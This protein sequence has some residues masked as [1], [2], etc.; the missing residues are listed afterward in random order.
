MTAAAPPRWTAYEPLRDV[1]PAVRNPKGHDVDRIAAS[2]ARFGFVDGAV[3]DGRTGRFIAGHGRLEAL[4]AME[5]RGDEPP[6]GV[7][8]GDRGWEMPVQM[9][10]SSR[11]DAHAEALL[12]MLNR[13]VELG[14]WIDADLVPMLDDLR[15]GD[16]PELLELSGFD[17]GQLDA[18]I[19]DLAAAADRDAEV[20]AYDPDALDDAPEE[21]A[22][23]RTRPGD[24]WVLGR[25]RVMCGSA[26]DPDALHR[27]LSGERAD[28]VW[29]DPPYGVAYEAGLSDA[30][31]VRLNRSRSRSG[32]AEIANDSLTPEDLEKL[33]TAAFT[34]ALAVS[35]P[36]AVWYIAAPAG[37]SFGVFIRALDPLGIWR[38]TLVWVKDRFAFGRQDYHYRHEQIMY[39]WA[40]G[41]AHHPPGGNGP[42]ADRTQDTVWEIPRPRR[43]DE[44]PTMKPVALITRALDNSSLPN[45]VVLDM[46]AGSGSTLIA[47]EVKARRARLVEIDP[48]RV[49]VICARFQRL[50]GT[51]PVLES[52]GEA[53]SFLDGNTPT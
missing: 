36:G 29:T 46:F 22:Q 48:F 49:D 8:V 25:H 40:P 27:V 53:V 10:W 33:L 38:Q 28:I 34:N 31:R 2:I 26:T 16:S 42:G 13:G 52:S 23:P 17:P 20:P 41:A 18:M 47:A 30:D 32:P 44:H 15:L 7:V 50:T 35:R 39:G 1:V 45:A 51:V 5:A 9:G 43:S 24:I 19:A 12:I 14:G 11:D 6:E 4:S 3:H 21:P 37:Q